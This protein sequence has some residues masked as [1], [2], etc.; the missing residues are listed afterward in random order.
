MLSSTKEN[1][2]Y[3]TAAIELHALPSKKIP[4]P[5][6][7]LCM[8]V[9]SV[10]VACSL[11]NS[12]SCKEIRYVA[13]LKFYYLSHIGKSKTVLAYLLFLTNTLHFDIYSGELL[14]D[15][16]FHS[17]LFGLYT[18]IQLSSLYSKFLTQQQSEIFLSVAVGASVAEEL[19]SLVRNMTLDKLIMYIHGS[20]FVKQIEQQKILS[21]ARGGAEEAC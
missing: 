13:A 7:F 5:H 8:A 11:L 21:S 18:L 19:L 3:P 16:A 12:Y 9:P 10:S 20:P 1:A 14:I 6:Q 15:I 4:A 2:L 17:R